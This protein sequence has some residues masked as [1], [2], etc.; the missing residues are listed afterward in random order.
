MNFNNILIE[1]SLILKHHS[2]NQTQWNKVA[3]FYIENKLHIYI[4]VSKLFLL[5]TCLKRKEKIFYEI[6]H[7]KMFSSC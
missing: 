4:S 6:I 5:K 7:K 2:V 3:V 1:S